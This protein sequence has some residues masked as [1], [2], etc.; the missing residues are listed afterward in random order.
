ML[1]EQIVVDWAEDS[2]IFTYDEL[3]INQ[4]KKKNV[5]ILLWKHW[6]I[7]PSYNMQL[8]D[9]IIHVLDAVVDLEEEWDKKI[10]FSLFFNINNKKINK[11]IVEKLEKTSINV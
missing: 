7:A 11:I 10:S 5:E 6:V 3:R 2:N 8:K 4:V 1:V 9:N